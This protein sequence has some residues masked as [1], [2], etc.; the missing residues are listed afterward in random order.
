[1]DWKEKNEPIPDDIHQFDWQEFQQE[2]RDYID[3][4]RMAQSIPDHFIT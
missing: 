1:M 3:L 4:A 2:Y